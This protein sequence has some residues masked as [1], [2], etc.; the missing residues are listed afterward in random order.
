[1]TRDS[2]IAQIARL[3][4]AARV[5]DWHAHATIGAPATEAEIRQCEDALRTRMP[6]NYAETLREWNGC[7]VELCE[8]PRGGEERGRVRVQWFIS[9]SSR[10]SHRR[11]TLA[12]RWPKQWRGRMSP[13][14]LPT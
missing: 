14:P 8:A 1:M 4:A 11:K 3:D 7:T 2:L 5:Q 12:K 6:S 9:G 10:L 13:R